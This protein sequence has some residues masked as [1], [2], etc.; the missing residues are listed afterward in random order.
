MNPRKIFCGSNVAFG[1]SQRISTCTFSA[2]KIQYYFA[3]LKELRNIKIIISNNNN[4][5]LQF[6]KTINSK[7]QL[8]NLYVWKCRIYISGFQHYLL[9]SP[10]IVKTVKTN[11]T[12]FYKVTVGMT[13]DMWMMT[14][15]IV[16]R[17]AMRKMY[18]HKEERDS[19]NKIVYL[20]NREEFRSAELIRGIISRIVCP[21]IKLRLASYAH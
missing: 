6:K 1:H 9:C 12:I 2:L 5:K 18:I 19:V 3:L 15:I 14:D 20:F 11:E 4:V 10:S 8:D 16:F 13:V 7:Y 17:K 21:F